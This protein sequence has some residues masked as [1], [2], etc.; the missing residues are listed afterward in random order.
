MACSLTVTTGIGV[1]KKH[2]M[3]GPRALREM[4]QRL[5]NASRRVSRPSIK[6]QNHAIPSGQIRLR[7]GQPSKRSKHTR[8]MFK[9]RAVSSY[10][11]LALR[12]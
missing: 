3:K 5:K 1:E 9:N 7:Q 10:W 11:H 4:E 6:D 8:Q 2:G 12:P